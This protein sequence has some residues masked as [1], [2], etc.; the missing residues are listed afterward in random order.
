MQSVTSNAVANALLSPLI[1]ND[2]LD[3]F[4]NAWYSGKE[5]YEGIFFIRGNSAHSPITSPYSWF[6][7]TLHKTYQINGYVITQMTINTDP[8][9]IYTRTALST[10]NQNWA[11]QSWEKVLTDNDLGDS[12]G[13]QRIGTWIDGSPLYKKAIVFNIPQNGNYSIPIDVS[14][15]KNL[16]KWSGNFFQGGYQAPQWIMH[17]PYTYIDPLNPSDILNIY[18]YFAPNTLSFMTSF[19]GI[20]QYS[21]GYFNGQGIL[22]IEYTK[23]N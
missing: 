17:I 23:N 9:M 1:Y 4:N 19:Y 20:G 15:F 16:V 21:S 6:V 14:N 8:Y 3:D 5:N 2:I 18:V 10:D 22:Y 12:L 13:E 7:K 11:W